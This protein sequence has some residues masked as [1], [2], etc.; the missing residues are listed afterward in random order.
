MQMRNIAM[1][2]GE[3]DISFSVGREFSELILVVF[4]VVAVADIAQR[5]ITIWLAMTAVFRVLPGKESRRGA[6][7]E[8][9]DHIQHMR[10]V[11][12][13]FLPGEG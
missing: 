10:V 8:L 1:H 12:G 13:V 7:I 6:C 2:K 3:I 4:V 9:Y 5:R 11:A